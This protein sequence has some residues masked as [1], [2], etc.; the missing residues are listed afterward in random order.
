MKQRIYVLGVFLTVVLSGCFPGVKYRVNAYYNALP[1]PDGKGSLVYGY[2]Y[3]SFPLKEVII[4]KMDDGRRFRADLIPSTV[5]RNR[6]RNFFYITNVP[7]GKYAIQKIVAS[8]QSRG[9]RSTTT[10]YQYATFKRGSKYR[11]TVPANG[12]F[13]L[14]RM[15]LFKKTAREAVKKDTPMSTIHDE[16]SDQESFLLVF[17]KESDLLFRQ[18]HAIVV[19][20]LK[21][22]KAG[23]AW[24]DVVK[25]TLPDYEDLV[26]QVE[27]DIADRN[28]KSSDADSDPATVPF[29]VL[30]EVKDKNGKIQTGSIR[31]TPEQAR[32]TIEKFSTLIIASTQERDSMVD[33]LVK[34]LKEGKW[35]IFTKKIND[36]T[37]SADFY[38]FPDAGLK[39]MLGMAITKNGKKSIYTVKLVN[40]TEVKIEFQ[41]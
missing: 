36:G 19:N 41:L 12:S 23:P 31:I 15:A 30:K 1:D 20:Q 9:F 32:Q 4:V 18:R 24:I 2:L 22:Y 16:E 26:K 28:S 17:L 21:G 29:I 11:F 25:K 34:G 39:N 5:T 33:A 6:S 35:V 27:K 10:S 3:S 7:E 38:F 40:D 37:V 14:G 8:T 13:Y